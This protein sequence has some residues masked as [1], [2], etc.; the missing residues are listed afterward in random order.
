MSPRT[1]EVKRF[2]GYGTVY[3]DGVTGLKVVKS[4]TEAPK[5]I[6]NPDGSVSYSTP[7]PVVHE[8]FG[9]GFAYADGSPVTARIHLENITDLQMKEKALKWFDSGGKVSVE[10]TSGIPARDPDAKQ[11]PPETVFVVS[12]DFPEKG[13]GQAPEIIKDQTT[14]DNTLSQVLSA[15]ETLAG[16]VT[17]QAD[18]IKTLKAVYKAVHPRKNPGTSEKLKNR[19]KDPEYRAKM[20]KKIKEKQDGAAQADPEV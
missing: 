16:V 15:I 11:E 17:K 6:F 1:A 5:R 10:A 20:L 7:P 8:V 3:P 2:P 9:G 18:D 19:W 4:Y 13:V 12:T 14:P